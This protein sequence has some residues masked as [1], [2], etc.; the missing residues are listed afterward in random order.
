M[1]TGL[2]SADR[3]SLSMSPSGMLSALDNNEE[4]RALQQ[5][6]PLRPQSNEYQSHPNLGSGAPWS[7]SLLLQN[8][9]SNY[10]DDSTNLYTA[11]PATTYLDNSAS[12]YNGVS[13]DTYTENSASE[14]SADYSTERVG[15]YVPVLAGGNTGSDGAWLCQSPNCDFRFHLRNDLQIHYQTLHAGFNEQDA[16]E[17]FRCSLCDREPDLHSRPCDTWGQTWTWTKWYEYYLPVANNFTTN[18]AGPATFDGNS[19]GSW[20][21]GGF[22][23]FG[24]GGY[25][26]GAG[27]SA[28][29]HNPGYGGGFMY[30]NGGG[31]YSYRACARNGRIALADDEERAGPPGTGKVALSL[32][33]WSKKEAAS[34]TT[35]VHPV[36][37]AL[38]G[39]CIRRMILEELRKIM[40]FAR[41]TQDPSPA[42]NGRSSTAS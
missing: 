20:T 12:P 39:N 7:A 27:S 1:L 34:S 29:A 15:K 21:S 9:A 30:G 26:G 25:F 11:I 22:N 17:V 33:Q 35:M 18:V 40:S 19:G 24:D 5:Q 8:S 32:R 31:G 41:L 3:M 23:G 13:A 38:V 36:F 28:S 10:P 16:R 4:D 2:H 6:I 42:V 37:A 14:Y